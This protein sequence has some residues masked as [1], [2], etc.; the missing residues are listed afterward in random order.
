MDASRCKGKKAQR[1]SE[2]NS[3][4]AIP[5]MFWDVIGVKVLFLL[6]SLDMQHYVAFN[7]SVRSY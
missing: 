7:K 4:P 1:S 3:V 5:I 2:G 6:Y